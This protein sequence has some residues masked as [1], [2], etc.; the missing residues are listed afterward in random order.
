MCAADARPNE[1]DSPDVHGSITAF[2]ARAEIDF[3][4]PGPDPDH[5]AWLRALH[6]AFVAQYRT[7]HATERFV[8]WREEDR[9]KREEGKPARNAKDRAAYAHM[10]QIEEGRE[11]RGYGNLTVEERKARNRA[12]A[13]ERK[14]AQRVRARAAKGA[15]T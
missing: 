4:P 9:L 14:R 2:V 12:L 13:A 3:R 5:L 7:T 10:I 15:A 6:P 1:E 8:A 11:V